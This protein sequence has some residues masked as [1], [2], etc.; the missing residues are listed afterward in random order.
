MKAWRLLLQFYQSKLMKQI[1]AKRSA[2]LA[3]A[4]YTFRI[5]KREAHLTAGVL[6]F[7]FLWSQGSELTEMLGK[8]FDAIALS[9]GIGRDLA[10]VADAVGKLCG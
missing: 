1:S 4:Y 6:F 3:T 10:T 9:G 8:F 7:W 2:P 5:R